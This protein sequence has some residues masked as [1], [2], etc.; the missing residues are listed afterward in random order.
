MREQG[1]ND[2]RLIIRSEGTP[3]SR[4]YNK[5]TAPEVA[6]IMPGVGHGEEAASRDIVLHAHSGGLSRITE[7]HRAYDALHC[8]YLSPR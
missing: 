6:A 1:H 5:T 8:Y 4:R 7:I 3:D 2:V